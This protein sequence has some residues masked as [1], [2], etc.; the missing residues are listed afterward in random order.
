M[1]LLSC[2]QLKQSQSAVEESSALSE[3][4]NLREQL[5]KSEE[6]RKT[7]ETQLSDANSLVTRLQ[8]E[9]TP[10]CLKIRPYHNKITVHDM[11]YI[12]EKSSDV[13][14]IFRFS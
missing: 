6:E 5:E 11:E 8:E 3:L 2:D 4:Q 14:E 10:L 12:L 13:L 9:G 1:P 7:L